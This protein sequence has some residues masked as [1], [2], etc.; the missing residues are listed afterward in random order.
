ME[1]DNQDT[2]PDEPHGKFQLAPTTVKL[3]VTKM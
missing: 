1:T 2:A 3:L